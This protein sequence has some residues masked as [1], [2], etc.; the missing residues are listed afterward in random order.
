M[1]VFILS[2]DVNYGNYVNVAVYLQESDAILKKHELI[3]L[4]VSEGYIEIEEW[5]VC[6]T[7]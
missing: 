6:D 7:Y 4:G 3:S 5:D 2:K 1:K